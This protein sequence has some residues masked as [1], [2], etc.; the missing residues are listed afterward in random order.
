[1]TPRPAAASIDE[2]IA[3]FPP[4]TREVLQ[5]LRAVIKAAVPEAVEGISYAIPVFD[6]GGRHLVFLAGYEKHVGLYPVMPAVAAALGEE[7]R[8]YRHGKAS[9]R[10]PLGRPLPADLIARVVRAMVAERAREAT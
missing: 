7:L 5:Q 8:P 4:A 9:L 2:Y 3:A 10:F 6:L 1:M